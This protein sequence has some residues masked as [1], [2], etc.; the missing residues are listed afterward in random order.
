M[1]SYKVIDAAGHPHLQDELINYLN[2]VITGHLAPLNVPPCPM[3]LDAWLGGQ[4]LYSGDT[5]KMGAHFI[6]T[7]AIEGFLAESY[8]NILAQLK[9]LRSPFAFPRG[10]CP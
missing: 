6:A 4:E 2:F 10:S 5:P 8:P 7:V 3:Y 9:R 1:K